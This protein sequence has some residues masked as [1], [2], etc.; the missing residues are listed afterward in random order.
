M[1]K[2]TLQCVAQCSKFMKD[3]GRTEQYLSNSLALKNAV[4]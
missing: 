1:E 4:K 3:L 2:K